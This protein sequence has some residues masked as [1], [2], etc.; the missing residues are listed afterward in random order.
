MHLKTP[1][2]RLP[3][4]ASEAGPGYFLVGPVE[5]PGV[6]GTLKQWLVV[7]FPASPFAKAQVIFNLAFAGSWETFKNLSGRAWIFLCKFRL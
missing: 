2:E 4:N 6:S 3:G 5:T 7:R 1:L